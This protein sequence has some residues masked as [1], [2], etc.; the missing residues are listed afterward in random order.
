MIL[1]RFAVLFVMF[2]AVSTCAVA[3]RADIGFVVGLSFA[4]DTTL[5]TGIVCITAPCPTAFTVNTGHHIFYAGELS[6]RVANFQIASV[7]LELPMAG[8]PSAPLKFTGTVTL[9][10]LS[11]VFVTPS[12]KIKLLPHSAI[13]PFASVGIGSAHYDD[14]TIACTKIAYQVGGGL[15]FRS[16]IP[17]FGFRAEVRDYISGVPHLGLV[18]T[19]IASSSDISTRR[20]NFLVGA[21]IV[22]KF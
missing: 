13:S 1:R 14:G 22:V 4:S 2:S 12:L 18:S 8:V 15:D 16:P 21:G 10:H 5:P 9:T 19:A 3:Q 20:N 17:L 11:S 7:H 6:Y